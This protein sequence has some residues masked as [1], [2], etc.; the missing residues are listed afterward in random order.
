MRSIER[1]RPLHRLLED[2]HALAALLEEIPIA[3]WIYGAD[4]RPITMNRHAVRVIGGGV[5]DAHQV[6]IRN[7]PGPN[8]ELFRP[9]G[10][11]YR[12]DE[13]PVVRALRG[14][15]VRDEQVI[16]VTRWR[17]GIYLVNTSPLWDEGGRILGSVSTAQD[18]RVQKQLEAELARGRQAAL[19]ASRSKSRMLYA[20]SHDLRL[21]LNSIALSVEL[22]LSQVRDGQDREVCDAAER[23]RRSLGAITELL[24]DGLRLARIEAGVEP[25]H[26]T[27]F[28]LG[29]LVTECLASVEPEAGLKG[30]ELR[31]EDPAQAAALEVTTDRSKLRQIIL[32]LLGNAVRYTE[33]GWVS[34]RAWAA[35]DGIRI[36]VADTGPGIAPEDRERVFHEYTRLE[37]GRRA[38]I[39]GSGLGLAIAQRLAGLLSGRIELESTVGAGSRF[40]LVLPRSNGE[41]KADSAGDDADKAQSGEGDQCDC[42]D[43]QPDRSEASGQPQDGAEDP[44]AVPGGLELAGG[45]GGARQVRHLDLEDAK[46]ARDGRSCQ[47]GLDLE[48]R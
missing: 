43:G 38:A 36:A 28:R 6:V 11:P 24:D 8:V 40:T 15:T 21:P 33:Q 26:P 48:A 31:F 27:Q 3:V 47:F 34:V 32:N 7:D 44:Q 16:V 30:L 41:G 37:S 35:P 4:G 39:R 1:L 18:I 12:F 20:L 19:E 2:P 46:P 14:E 10:T 25:L 17:A 5:E 9:D 22:L 13:Y 29:E 23:I 45:S 42:D